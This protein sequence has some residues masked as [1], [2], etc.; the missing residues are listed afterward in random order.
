MV[1]PLHA[2]ILSK[3]DFETYKPMFG[4]YLDI[5][6]QL[7]LEELPP[8][9][10]RGRWKSFVGKWYVRFT[11]SIILYEKCFYKVQLTNICEES[12]RTS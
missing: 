7:V 9:E 6:K 3:H 5:Q 1:L 8:D 11:E 10:M 12:W 2:S 4:L